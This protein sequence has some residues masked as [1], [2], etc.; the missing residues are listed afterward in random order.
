MRP[1]KLA[2]T[3]FVDSG[4]LASRQPLAQRTRCRRLVVR[5][6]VFEVGKALH[7]ACSLHPKHCAVCGTCSATT[8]N[9]SASRV[10]SNNKHDC[11]RMC[12]LGAA[13]GQ[14]KV[15]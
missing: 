1:E 14:H 9:V 15:P 2:V 12:L 8:D 13:D 6:G 11:R 10:S 5:T 4:A 7:V 3:V